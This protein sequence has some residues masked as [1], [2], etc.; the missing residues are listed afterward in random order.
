MDTAKYIQS[1]PI[2]T[3]RKF[4]NDEAAEYLGVQSQTL[5]VWRCTGR[6]DIPYLKVGRK[7]YYRQSVL[8]AWLESRTVSH[9]GQSFAK[10]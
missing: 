5:S 2:E 4:T 6:Y 3:D 1:R 9:T 8:D 7:I 10:A